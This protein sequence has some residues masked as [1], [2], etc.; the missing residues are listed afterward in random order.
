MYGLKKPFIKKTIGPKREKRRHI[1]K[2]TLEVGN[3]SPPTHATDKDQNVNGLK[4]KQVHQQTH[5]RT[6]HANPHAKDRRRGVC[7]HRDRRARP[8]NGGRV[9]PFERASTFAATVARSPW[10]ATSAAIPSAMQ[11]P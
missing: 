2:T 6:L 4:R 10:R 5:K 1:K 8:G 3:R 7:P 11:A 9:T